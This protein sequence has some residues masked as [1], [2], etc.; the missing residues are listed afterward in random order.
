MCAFNTA[1]NFG[2]VMIELSVSTLGTLV[3]IQLADLTT[4]LT[5]C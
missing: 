3:G 1:L 5:G 2:K 4:F